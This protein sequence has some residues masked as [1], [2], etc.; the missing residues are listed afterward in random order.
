M[1]G[2][3]GMFV[4]AGGACQLYVRVADPWTFF[5][6]FGALFVFWLGIALFIGALVANGVA[7]A[8]LGLLF[9]REKGKPAPIY[10]I[11]EAKRA[12]GEY[13]EAY[14]YF[15]GLSGRF[16]QEV[17]PYVE[18]MELALLYLGNPGLAAETYEE[19]RAGLK[20]KTAREELEWHYRR[21]LAEYAGQKA[22]ANPNLRE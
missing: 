20:K 15:Q 22:G 7:S 2:L 21:F 1:V 13:A 8:F 16:P 3:G 14:Y 5:P 6:Y 19:G 11:G 4:L 12:K 9:A 10:G 18:R 17:R